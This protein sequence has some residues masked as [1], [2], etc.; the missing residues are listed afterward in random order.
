M[1]GRP[2]GYK[3]TEETKKKIG[4]GNSIAL[5]GNKYPNKG[6]FKKGNKPW[7]SG[8]K[9]GPQSEEIKKKRS[10]SI[11][12]W[13]K[14]IKD[15]KIGNERNKKISLSQLKE[16]NNSW[17]G[18]VSFEKYSVDWTN[19]LKKSIR[20]RDRFQCIICG[21]DKRLAVHHIDYDKK[22]NNPTN[23]ISLCIKCHGKTGY[24]REKWKKM[25]QQLMI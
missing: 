8:K 1:A 23:L 16:L 6:K 14:K 19:T 3:V 7:N 17:Q 22:N 11:K 12:K 4:K 25:F 2:H 10:A 9:T 20:E 18:G 13:H 15:T 24:N 5:K 21:D